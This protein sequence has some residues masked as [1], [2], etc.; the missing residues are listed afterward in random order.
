MSK[1]VVLPLMGALLFAGCCKKLEVTDCC[2][3]K[4][5]DIKTVKKIIQNRDALMEKNIKL[6]ANG[7]GVAPCSDTCSA[8]QAYA[9]AR[10][11]AILDAYKALAEKV[12]GIKINARDSVKNMVL[13]NS[14]IKSYVQGLIKKADI[15]SESY[16]DGIYKV[17]MSLNI[18][19]SELKS[20]I[21]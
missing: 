1:K 2:S 17:R 8:A 7:V 14:E 19:E 20:K 3:Q 12:Y 13:Q 21:Y 15:V 11:A 10:R 18:S 16:K 6:E 4:P 5:A 9:M